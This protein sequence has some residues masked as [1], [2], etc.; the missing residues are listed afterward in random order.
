MGISTLPNLQTNELDDFRQDRNLKIKLD[1]YDHTE[2]LNAHLCVTP[3]DLKMFTTERFPPHC[4]VST[5]VNEIL[6]VGKHVDVEKG[7]P[8]TP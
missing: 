5:D 1:Q 3:I 6:R 8:H 2:N 7:T 4:Y